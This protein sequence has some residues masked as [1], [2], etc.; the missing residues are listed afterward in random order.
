[1]ASY[2]GQCHCGAVGFEFHTEITPASWSVRACQCT[3]CLKHA[4]VYTSDP[5]GSV[6]FTHREPALL[7]RYRFGHRTAD[8]VFCGHCGGYLGAITEEGGQR[9]AVLNIHALDPQP[10]GLPAAQ[11]MS[12]DGETTADRG[13]RRSRRWTPVI[14]Q[15]PAT[16]R[17]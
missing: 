5:A 1:V 14:G 12:Y 16:G 4:G 11:P 7:T 9:L 17:L 15:A 8:F 13:S 2:R 10:E 3:F 6:R